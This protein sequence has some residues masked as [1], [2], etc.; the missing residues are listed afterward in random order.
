MTVFGDNI[1]RIRQ[2]KGLLIKELSLLSGVSEPHI[3]RLENGLIEDPRIMSIQKIATVLNTT[4][5]DLLESSITHLAPATSN[6]EGD[7]ELLE[8]LIKIFKMMEPLDKDDKLALLESMR[9]LVLGKK[10]NYRS[11]NKE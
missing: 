9:Y 8:K 4:V 7:P 2:Q 11:K 3:S 10:V 6:F 5:D 1:K